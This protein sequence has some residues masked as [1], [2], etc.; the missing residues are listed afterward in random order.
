MSI[1]STLQRVRVLVLLA[2]VA[3][4]CD[5]AARA[6]EDGTLGV[7]TEG[8]RVLAAEDIEWVED[9]QLPGVRSA[10]LWGDPNSGKEHA[11]LRRFPAGYAPPPHSHPSTESVVMIAGHIVVEHEGGERRVLGPG[12]YSQIPANMVHAVR[13]TA[14]AE[15]IFLLRSPGLF[16]I[17]FVEGQP[18]APN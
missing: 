10:V 14:E 12:S 16:T 2:F 8:P 7:A 13:C 17:K 11:L 18:P 9:P 5:T 15:C 3:L 4:A 6:H 1:T